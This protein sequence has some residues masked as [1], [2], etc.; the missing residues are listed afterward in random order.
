MKNKIIF[1]FI[2]VLL[3]T[4]CDDFL[5]PVSQDKIVPE[6]VCQLREYLLGEVISNE[7]D[8]MCFVD[9]MTDDVTY[10]MPE[11]MRRDMGARYFGYYTWQRDPEIGAANA[12]QPD[13]CWDMY[14][15]HIFTCNIILDQEPDMNGTDEERNAL[16]G[17]TYFMRANYYFLLVNMYGEPYDE[18]REGLG[19]PINDEVG[20]E[21]KRYQ[22]SSVKEVYEKIEE[23][24]LASIKYFKKASSER[25]IAMPSIHAAYLLASRMYLYKKDYVNTKKYADLLISEMGGCLGDLSKTKRGKPFLTD[26]NPEMIFA[27]SSYKDFILRK[28]RSSGIPIISE[29]FKDIFER[30]DLRYNSYCY[31]DDVKKWNSSYSHCRGKIFRLSEAYLNRAEANVYLGSIGAAMSDLETIREKR[32]SKDYEIGASGEEDAIEKVRAERRR[33]LCFEYHRW[34]DLRRYGM[35][36][37]V[38]TYGVGN[39]EEYVL[40]E[41]DAAYTLPIPMSVRNMNTTIEKINRPN[42]QK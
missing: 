4:S 32:F 13:I 23:D 16:K 8:D 12:Q 31:R 22:R 35:P 24:L 25:N 29:E 27:Y 36:R 1:L 7:A 10:S 14:Y 38:H 9:L 2:S 26:E 40:E 15:H 37:L 42:R 21:N 33:E 39:T 41:G 18:S 30:N 3:L 20:I 19:V 28:S 34:F 11:G 17:M 6:D 5:E